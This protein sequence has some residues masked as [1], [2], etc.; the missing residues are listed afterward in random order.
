V[1]PKIPNRQTFISNY[2]DN[3]LLFDKNNQSHTKEFLKECKD[4]VPLNK[5]SDEQR[6][7]ML[8]LDFL[9]KMNTSDLKKLFMKGKGPAMEDPERTSDQIHLSNKK[10]TNSRAMQHS[11][12]PEDRRSANDF[13]RKNND[14]HEKFKVKDG[15]KGSAIF[16]ESKGFNGH[17]FNGHNVSGE[18][19][20]VPSRLKRPRRSKSSNN[21]GN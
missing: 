20:R 8:G 6:R 17:N 21:L 15:N 3:T 2:Q 19:N 1:K 16:L 14:K 7:K 18:K 4:S 10:N 11:K 12:S 5:L 13:R 9:N